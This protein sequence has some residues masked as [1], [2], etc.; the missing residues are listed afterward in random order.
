[1]QDNYISL[2]PENTA[3]EE[4]TLRS[5]LYKQRLLEAQGGEASVLVGTQFGLTAAVLTHSY[6]AGTGFKLLPF[7]PAKAPGYGKVLGAFLGFYMLGHG[8]VMGAFGDSKYFRYLYLNKRGIM[9]GTTT[10]EKSE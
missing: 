5:N 2:N 3:S 4:K 7:S 9:N 1:M 8:Y 10:W 6:L